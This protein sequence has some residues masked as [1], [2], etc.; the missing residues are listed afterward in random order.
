MPISKRIRFEVF[1]RDSF[2]CQYCGQKAPDI[3]LH[4]DHIEPQSLDG[5]DTITNLL[6]SCEACNLGK[7]NIRLSDD[8]AIQKQR[9]QLELLQERREQLEMMME[10]HRGLV[11]IEA[12]QLEEIAQFWSDLV[13]PYTLNDTGVS[14]LRKLIQKFGP[15]EAIESIKI[16]V[17]YYL[18]RDD[19][20]KPI[21]ESV[22]LTWHKV[23]G[24]C[25]VRRKE[26]DNPSIKDIYYIR[27]IL[28]KRLS[29]INEK[30]IL[31]ILRDALKIGITSDEIKQIAVATTSW[32][33]FRCSIESLTSQEK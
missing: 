14:A 24:V 13:S 9:H 11:D 17:G 25:V 2:T 8:S 6:T 33:A 23:G 20:G 21:A 28:R 22:E 18:E 31:G 7:S 19:E 1:K 3:V 15:S 27:G 12:E 4:L 16:A 10:W 30:L 5:D 26:M 29:Y 32:T